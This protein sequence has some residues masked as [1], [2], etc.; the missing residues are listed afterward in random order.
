MNWKTKWTLHCSWWYLS[1][2]V[3]VWIESGSS[4]TKNNYDENARLESKRV[5]V[6]GILYFTK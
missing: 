3:F 1:K 4:K 6:S 2:N 5:R